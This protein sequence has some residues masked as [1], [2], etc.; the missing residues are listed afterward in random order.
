[1]RAQ[2][3]QPTAPW[4]FEAELHDARQRA[5]QATRAKL[6]V[7]RSYRHNGGIPVFASLAG[8]RPIATTQTYIDVNDA[9][10]RA[11]AELL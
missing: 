3:K 7:N 9:M 5:G 2:Q 10:K 4:G 11:A 8:H 1:M 6:A